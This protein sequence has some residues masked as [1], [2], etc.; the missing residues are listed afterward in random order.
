M[1]E[2]VRSIIFRPVSDKK[3][4]QMIE[5]LCR[6]MNAKACIVTEIEDKRRVPADQLERLY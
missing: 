4:E 5:Y 2:K 3:Y 1:K 6:N